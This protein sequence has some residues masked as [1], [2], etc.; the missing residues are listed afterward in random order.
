MDAIPDEIIR[1]ILHYLPYDE[2]SKSRMICRRFNTLG[3]QVLNDGFRRVRLFHTQCL[4]EIKDELPRRESERRKHHLYP[5]HDVLQ[6]IET[7]LSLLR[8]T[9]SRLISV[10]SICFI[11]GKVLDELFRILGIVQERGTPIQ[12][13]LP[14]LREMRDISSMAM[15]HFEEEILPHVDS[16]DIAA[17]KSIPDFLMPSDFLLPTPCQSPNETPTTPP[18]SRRPIKRQ[19]RINHTVKL[20]DKLSS[21]NRMISRQRVRINQLENVTTSLSLTVNEQKGQISEIMKQLGVLQGLFRDQR[22]VP[23]S[24]VPCTSR[25]FNNNILSFEEDFLDELCPTEK[26]IL[27]DR[28]D[29]ANARKAKRRKKD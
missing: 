5:R 1:H 23:S 21:Q 26:R 7:R 3:G 25:D 17:G 16:T 8:M 10:G 12:N 11:P 22:R 9:Y 15:E 19:N 4:K 13:S 14:L 2:V 18:S 24:S 20:Y 29:L 27:P 28:T 6:A